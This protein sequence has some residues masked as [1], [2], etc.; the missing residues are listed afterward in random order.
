MTV[1]K[2]RG[3]PLLCAAAAT[4]LVFGAALVV[5]IQQ[6]G[7]AGEPVAASSAVQITLDFVRPC[8]I[9]RVTLPPGGTVHIFPGDDSSPPI[10][11]TKCEVGNVH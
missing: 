1:I 2:S 6:R 3:F 7:I 11:A 10:I 5:S 9:T 8:L 4:L